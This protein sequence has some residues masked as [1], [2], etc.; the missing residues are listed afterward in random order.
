MT[1]R[2]I[3][4]DGSRVDP[5]QVEPLLS[6]LPV[7]QFQLVQGYSGRITLRYAGEGEVVAPTELARA[8]ARLLGSEVDLRLE[9]SS[10]PLWQPGEKPIPYRS[11]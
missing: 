7:R 9:R 4:A 2:F 1:H 11:E 5:S 3:A 6:K 8:L 10:A